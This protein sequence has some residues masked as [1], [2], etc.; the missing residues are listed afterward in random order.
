MLVLILSFH[1]TAFYATDLLNPNVNSLIL[2]DTP[3]SVELVFV[4]R[5]HEATK[6]Q[7]HQ[8]QSYDAMMQGIM[9]ISI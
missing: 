6:L 7:M 2:K 5:V 3:H 4:L 9:F 1:S 8:E